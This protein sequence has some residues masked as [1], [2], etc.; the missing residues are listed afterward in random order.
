MDPTGAAIVPLIEAQL[1]ALGVLSTTD[2]TLLA[3]RRLV[4]QAIAAGIVQHIQSTATITIPFVTGVT[5]G[6]GVSG[7][8]VG[9]PPTGGII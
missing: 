5:T 1:A 2:P 3:E 4:L 6:A 7:P 8:G 9:T